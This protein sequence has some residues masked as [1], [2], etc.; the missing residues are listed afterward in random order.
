MLLSFVVDSDGG[1]HLGGY[2]K[3]PKPVGSWDPFGRESNWMVLCCL[4]LGKNS[5]SNCE[6]LM[7]LKDISNSNIE[8]RDSGR[9]ARS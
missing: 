2:V 3:T 8:C 7:V 4:T 6:R 1:V 5:S 9:I